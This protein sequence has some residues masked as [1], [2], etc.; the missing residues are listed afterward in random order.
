M[1][2]TRAEF[3]SR[4]KA[5]SIFRC[6][7]EVMGF[8]VIFASIFATF[9]ETRYQKYSTP[10]RVSMIFTFE[11]VFTAVISYFTFGKPMSVLEMGG[12]AVMILGML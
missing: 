9:L 8:N 2:K 12:G 7:A 4:W 1:P 6:R 11:P 10:A 3:V 5:D